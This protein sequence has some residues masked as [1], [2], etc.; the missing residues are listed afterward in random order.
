MTVNMILCLLENININRGNLREVF[1][2]DL[3]ILEEI[4]S[5]AIDT[6]RTINSHSGEYF[7]YVFE[8]EAW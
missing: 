1:F 8:I 3:K 7:L 4:I 5:A 2:F 6:E